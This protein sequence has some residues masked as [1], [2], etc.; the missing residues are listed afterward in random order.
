[1]FDSGHKKKIIYICIRVA[2]HFVAV[3]HLQ[4]FFLSLFFCSCKSIAPCHFILHFSILGTTKPCV[5]WNILLLDYTSMCVAKRFREPNWSHNNNNK[6]QFPSLCWKVPKDWFVCRHILTNRKMLQSERIQLIYHTKYQ[7]SHPKCLM[8]YI[9]HT[10]HY[11][12]INWM[13]A[14]QA[15]NFGFRV[16]TL[17]AHC[18]TI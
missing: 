13:T 5:T 11:F 2:L 14:Q 1:M 12:Q 16:C 17:H 18:L 15:F 6:F 8:S 7:H 3:S 4:R 10:L 9:K